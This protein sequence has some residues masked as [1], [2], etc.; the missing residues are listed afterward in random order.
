MPELAEFKAAHDLNL[1]LG[2]VPGAP[3]PADLP[4]RGEISELPASFCGQREPFS[5]TCWN[6]CRR[7][8]A[9]SDLQGALTVAGITFTFFFPYAVSPCAKKRVVVCTD[10]I[11][12]YVGNIIFRCS[13]CSSRFETWFMHLQR[14]NEAS[15]SA[16]HR[17]R[18]RVNE[19]AVFNSLSALAR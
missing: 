10:V 19:C 2:R 5:L 16:L 3:N 1:W 4:S 18:A 7:L 15:F 6:L 12:E 9:C 14:R 17:E 8:A 11:F 13:S